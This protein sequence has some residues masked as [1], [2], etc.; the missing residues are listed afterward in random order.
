ME[1]DLI[2]DEFKIKKEIEYVKASIDNLS[3]GNENYYDVL[4]DLGLQ[5]EVKI[6]YCAKN[7]QSLPE[8]LAKRANDLIYSM[9]QITHLIEINSSSPSFKKKNNNNATFRNFYEENK[10]DKNLYSKLKRF[11]NNYKRLWNGKYKRKINRVIEPVKQLYQDYVEFLESIV[12][13]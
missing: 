9:K 4:S 11:E 3:A 10:E 7:V 2:F 13:E 8:D 6:L 1:I 12:K 5:Q